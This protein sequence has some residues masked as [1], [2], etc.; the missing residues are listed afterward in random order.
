[1]RPCRNET[2]AIRG[3]TLAAEVAAI[4]I[5]SWAL[6]VCGEAARMSWGSAGREAFARFLVTSP[7]VAGDVLFRWAGAQGVHELGPETFEAQPAHVRLPF[8]VFAATFDAVLGV[9]RTEA[10]DYEAQRTAAIVS[11]RQRVSLSDTIFETDK[12]DGPFHHLGPRGS[13]TPPTR[14]QAAEAPALSVAGPLAE[15][16]LGDSA[17]PAPAPDPLT[18]AAA[19]DHQALGGSD[20]GSAAA[21]PAPQGVSSPT[22]APAVDQP[23]APL[24]APRGKRKG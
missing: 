24:S 14:H 22:R 3:A 18:P 7:G 1:M 11:R 6:A 17:A 20:P 23:P 12:D 13:F 21:D 5:E 9:L 10:A 8:A 16:P 19:G 4:E 2:D 15:P